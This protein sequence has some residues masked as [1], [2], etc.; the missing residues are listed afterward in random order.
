MILLKQSLDVWYKT[1]LKTSSIQDHEFK[2]PSMPLVC[3]KYAPSS[4]NAWGTCKSQFSKNSKTFFA[5]LRTPEGK[6]RGQRLKL[7]KNYDQL[8]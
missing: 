3:P 1:R 2:T 5:K 4:F 7:E 6:P 8:K